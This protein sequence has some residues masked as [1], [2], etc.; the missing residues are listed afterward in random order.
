MMAC[1]CP[2]PGGQQPKVERYSMT[3]D[4]FLD[5]REVTPAKLLFSEFGGQPLG[6]STQFVYFG[7]GFVRPFSALQKM[8]GAQWVVRL[9][10]S[11]LSAPTLP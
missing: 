5:E 9:R 3:V 6:T 10:R 7:G 11:T 1:L 8:E 2:A 4:S